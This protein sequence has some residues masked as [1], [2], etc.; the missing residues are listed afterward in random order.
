M[1][2]WSNFSNLLQISGF[3]LLLFIYHQFFVSFSPALLKIS[4][5]LPVTLEKVW[6]WFSV[7]IIDILIYLRLKFYITCYL[8]LINNSLGSQREYFLHDSVLFQV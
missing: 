8:Q 4:P 7:T 2:F 1:T 5:V 3:V 6:V